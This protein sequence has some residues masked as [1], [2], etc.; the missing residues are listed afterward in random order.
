MRRYLVLVFML[1]AL[2]PACANE[3]YLEGF[4]AANPHLRVAVSYLR[5]GNSDL[6]AIEIE[7]FQAKWAPLR[8]KLQPGPLATMVEGVGASA[9][10]ALEQVDAGKP[11]EAR[12]LLLDARQ[13]IHDTHAAAGLKPFADCI[14]SAIKVGYPLWGYREPP[15]NLGDAVTAKKIVDVNNAYLAALRG[16]RKRAPKD[17]A[18]DPEY[19]RLMDNADTSL[20]AIPATVKAKDGGQLYRYLI[21][22]RSIDRLLYFRFG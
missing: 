19:T 3:A 20:S 7:S 10:K 12:K 6:A 8:Q 21:E 22:L 17:V 13:R 15:P 14:W 1:A 2:T 9:A 18:A 5:T 16:C 4:E 11:D